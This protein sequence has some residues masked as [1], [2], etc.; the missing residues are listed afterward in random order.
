M[1]P[2]R[3]AAAA[4]FLRAFAIIGVHWVYATTSEVEGAYIRLK[5]ED[6]DLL[7]SSTCRKQRQSCPCRRPTTAAGVRSHQINSRA[8]AA[9]ASPG[10]IGPERRRAAELLVKTP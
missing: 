9:E 5:D 3:L 8:A 4:H 6:P 7:L 10:M 2:T 1:V